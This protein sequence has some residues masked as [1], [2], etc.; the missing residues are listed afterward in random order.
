MSRRHK[1]Q[2]A[3]LSPVELL[4]TFQGIVHWKSKPI[5]AVV[6]EI[7]VKPMSN[8]NHTSVN[9]ATQMWDKKQE[10]NLFGLYLNSA[11]IK[12]FYFK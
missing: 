8:T 4:H 7:N 1:Y 5:Y 9:C 3:D 10:E 2:P 12:P 11:T 6:R